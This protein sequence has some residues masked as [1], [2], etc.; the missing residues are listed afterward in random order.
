MSF[1]ARIP[2]SAADCSACFA[3]HPTVLAVRF[4]LSAR[5]RLPRRST[6]FD[7]VPTPEGLVSYPQIPPRTRVW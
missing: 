5:T 1:E 2:P 6:H 7:P 4:G 3:R